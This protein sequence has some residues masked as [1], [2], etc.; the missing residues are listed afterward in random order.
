MITEEQREKFP[1]LFATKKQTAFEE[2]INSAKYIRNKLKALRST[3]AEDQINMEKQV[4]QN[5]CMFEQLIEKYQ[6]YVGD[7]L[8]PQVNRYMRH[9]VHYT[10]LPA[11]E[12]NRYDD[13]ERDSK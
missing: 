6:K 4:I 2:K 11:F 9:S 7:D 5:Q 1:E 3:R 13:R 8:P 12:L 10:S